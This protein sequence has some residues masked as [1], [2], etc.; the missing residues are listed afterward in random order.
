MPGFLKLF[1]PFFL[2]T[3]DGYQY[4]YAAGQSSLDVF[5]IGHTQMLCYTYWSQRGSSGTIGLFGVDNISKPVHIYPIKVK[6]HW[7][8]F[9]INKIASLHFL[10]AGRLQT[11]ATRSIAKLNPHPQILTGL[12]LD[13]LFSPLLTFM[14]EAVIVYN[15]LMPKVFPGWEMQVGVRLNW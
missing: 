14:V 1:L 9:N 11:N 15:C 2:V 13:V 12:Q 10:G 4:N 8:L 7:E 3:P 6:K 5:F